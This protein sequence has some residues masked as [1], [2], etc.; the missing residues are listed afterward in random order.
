MTSYI[1]SEITAPVQSYLPTIRWERAKRS[2]NHVE[3]GHIRD[4]SPPERFNVLQKRA[5]DRVWLSICRTADARSVPWTEL[6][7]FDTVDD[8]KAAAQGHVDAGPV[9]TPIQQPDGSAILRGRQYRIRALCAEAMA[10]DPPGPLK[11]PTKLAPESFLAVRIT[12]IL[13]G[14]LDEYIKEA[15]A[16]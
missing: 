2:I 14:A 4:S 9:G 8:A 1:P 11:D 10:V 12:R 15:D 13:D 7:T 5:G 6:G 3:Y 16:L